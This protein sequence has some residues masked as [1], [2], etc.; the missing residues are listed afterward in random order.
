MTSC[1]DICNDMT[2]SRWLHWNPMKMWVHKV[3]TF[4]MNDADL[5]DFW[6]YVLCSDMMISRGCMCISLDEGKSLLVLQIFVSTW[7]VRH[8]SFFSNQH[9]D[10]P[11]S[12]FLY[13]AK[14]FFIFIT[15][16]SISIK[17]LIYTPKDWH[18]LGWLVYFKSISNSFN[19]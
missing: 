19:K 7:S 16:I 5:I 6:Q 12:R 13:R 4:I 3:S 1:P 17:I 8:F 15:F 11:A 14:I 9:A 2:V 10:T 18:P